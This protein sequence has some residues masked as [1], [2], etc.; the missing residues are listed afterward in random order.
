LEKRKGIFYFILVVGR[1][2]AGSR[3]RPAD[4]VSP[5]PAWPS[6]GRAAQ[7]ASLP[8]SPSQ[9]AQSILPC[10]PCGPPRP[11]SNA[12]VAAQRPRSKRLWSRVRN[13]LITDR[14][15]PLSKSVAIRRDLLPIGDRA[16]IVSA[17][18]TSRWI[19]P[20]K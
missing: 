15:H 20:Y 12:R 8:R 18:A 3:A 13:E 2:S 14:V 4:S 1:N 11:S 19:F 7:S 17:S 10:L 9:P 6:R 16:E 5:T